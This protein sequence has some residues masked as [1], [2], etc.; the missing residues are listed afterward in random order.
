MSLNREID[1][2]MSSR[3][4]NFGEENSENGSD[5]SEKEL[6]VELFEN[7]DVIKGFTEEGS[8]VT[9]NRL[10]GNLQNHDE[11][12]AEIM[13]RFAEVD[14]DKYKTFARIVVEKYLSKYKWYYS[15]M[16]SP[17]APSLSKAWAFYEHVT[18]ARYFEGEGEHKFAMAEPGECD[19]DTKLYSPVRTPSSALSEWGIGVAM[20]FSSVSKIGFLLLIAGVIS[21][22]NAIYFG[23]P[24]YG[25]NYRSSYLV[26]R[27]SAVCLRTG[28]VY[29]ANCE[30]E[31]WLD[32]A[33]A[34]A[35]YTGADDTTHTFVQHNLCEG[36]QMSQAMVT[37]G[38]LAFLIICFWLLDWYNQKLEVRFDESW[39]TASD[40][41]V[42]VKNPPPDANDPDEWKNFFKQFA[43][44][45]VS[46]CTVALNNQELMRA[47][48]RRKV[49]KYDLLDLLEDRNVD[50]DNE[51]EARNV[52]AKYRERKQN[53]KR[54]FFRSCLSCTILPLLR[55]LKL[56]HPTAEL[57]MEEIFFLK[58]EIMKLEKKKYDAISVF[59]TFE[60]EKGQR[61]AL[62]S[63]SISLFDMLRND[64]SS[65]DPS[66]LFRDEHILSVCEAPEPST[67]RWMELNYCQQYH[68]LLI[69]RFIT[70]SITVGLAIASGYTVREVRQEF[71]PFA[72]AIF[73]SF[74][75]FL[76]PN[77]V[78]IMLAFFEKHTTD[79]TYQQSLYLKVALFRWTNTVFLTFVISEDTTALGDDK[80][81]LLRTVSFVFVSELFVTPL[82][83][84]LDFGGLFRKHILA[85]RAETQQRM[86]YAFTGT[87]YNIGE[88]YTVSIN[89]A[90]IHF[91]LIQTRN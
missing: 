35:T 76:I 24:D 91:F 19:K 10:F 36:A 60:T 31:E 32:R 90:Q 89:L 62:Q 29:C 53:Q 67:V 37:F 39:I 75:N 34:Y 59:I 7:N 41:S 18:L 51:D 44:K 48:T 72:S 68:I 6:F 87:Y 28:W 77:A 82:L 12:T 78:K 56:A 26:L 69:Q 25:G 47:L 16:D 14:K 66:F 17:D 4:A 52:V 42:W 83:Q 80:V 50:L 38:T 64:S 27:G 15:P 88:R 65:M 54:S 81:D 8:T 73:M 70:F 63:L 23:S 71:G 2:Y 3:S 22:A 57:I 55:L 33:K 45:Q 21:L 61:T 40:Y 5:D 49:L 11:I 13:N 43:E 9:S 46:C 74:S 1:R 85:P 84:I 79:D 86:N 20:Y 58:Q 30:K